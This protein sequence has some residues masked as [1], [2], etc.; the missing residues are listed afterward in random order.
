MSTAKILITIHHVGGVFVWLWFIGSCTKEGMWNNAVTLIDAWMAAFLTFPL[1][2]AGTYL[3][4]DMLKPGPD[5]FYLVFAIVMG[6][7]WILYLIC[8]VII[9][10][11]TDRLSRTKV[12]FHPIVDKIGSIFFAW[13]L[14]GPVELLSWPILML[15]IL[16]AASGG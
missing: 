8:F 11:I 9:H 14:V 13:S 7:G 4:V 2:L 1:W 12:S 5:D 16:A 3:A 15:I 10:A 6:L